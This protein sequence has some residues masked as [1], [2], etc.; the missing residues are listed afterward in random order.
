MLNQDQKI[1]LVYKQILNGYEDV[2]LFA[3]LI[4]YGLFFFEKN[5]LLCLK[6]NNHE[7]FFKKEIFEKIHTNDEN[8]YENFKPNEINN[9]VTINLDDLPNIKEKN[10]DELLKINNENAKNK[11]R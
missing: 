3:L 6:I 10:I 11:N 2:N 7:Y 8:V 4:K 1:S 9:N 5:K